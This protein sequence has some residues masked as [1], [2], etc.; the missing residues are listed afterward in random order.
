MRGGPTVIVDAG[1]IV[2][3]L[4]RSDAHHA[5]ARSH[6]ERLRPPLLTCEAALAEAA[7]LVEY[8]GGD[9]A[10]VASLTAKGVF[11]P[12]PVLAEDAALVAQLMRRYRSVPMSL[13]DA[14]LVRLSEIASNAL[15]F[16]L[17]SDFRIYRRRGRTVIPVLIPEG[18]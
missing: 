2:A 16:T 14:C 4:N 7:F 12:V 15:V 11:R 6:F 8:A 17:D 13:A 18:R 5:W 3:W 10:V 1:P 9:P